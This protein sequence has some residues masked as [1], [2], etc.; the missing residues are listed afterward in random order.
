MTTRIGEQYLRQLGWYNPEDRNDHVTFIGVGGIGSFAAFGASKLGIPN[1]TIIDPDQVEAH[2]QPN[3]FYSIHDV[4]EDKVNA[5]AGFLQGESEHATIEPLHGIVASTEDGDCTEQ[6][7][8]NEL[9]GVVVSGLDSMEARKDV[10]ESSIKLNPRV[11]LYIDGRLGGQLIV[12]YAV[13]PT[14]IEDVDAYEATLHSD[15]EGIDAPCT[16]RGVIDVG[17][18]C[19]GMIVRLLR[20]HFAGQPVDKITLLQHEHASLQHGGWVGK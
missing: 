14:D 8:Y 12:L 17:L 1:I 15:D 19:A 4:G 5:L 2:N 6:G 18:V 10:W 13:D 3:Q 16:E 20:R 9:S 11:P 7:V